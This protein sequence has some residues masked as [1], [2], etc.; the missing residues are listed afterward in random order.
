M[1]DDDLERALRAARPSTAA[2]HGWAASADGDTAL[3]AIRRRAGGAARAQRSAL[4]RPR[5]LGLTA[6]I[7]AATAAAVTAESRTARIRAPKRI[8]DVHALT[9]VRLT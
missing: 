2:D 9:V 6:G 1:N 4:R 3:A 5:V 7:A 8:S